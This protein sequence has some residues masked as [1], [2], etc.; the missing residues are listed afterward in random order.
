MPINVF[1]SDILKTIAKQQ[2]YDDVKKQ[3]Q[4]YFNQ[5]GQAM[6][7]PETITVTWQDT[8][9]TLS[10][11]DLIVYCT[12]EDYSVVSSAFSGKKFDPLATGHWGY[13]Y[14]KNSGGSLEAAS[15]I[16]IKFFI[17]DTI[18]KLALHEL[19]H[20]KLNKGNELH[21]GNGLAQATVA[22]STTFTPENIAAL[23]AAMRNSVPQ[24]TG[25]YADL[26]S[27][28][29]RRDQGDQMWYL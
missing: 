14:I 25:G 7:P 16:Y 26:A 21:K 9:P 6:K 1:L 3:L 4:G 13:T 8:Q 12:S 15:E 20:N 28:K 19:M 11:Q 29:K 5:I 22:S 17:A 23:A 10:S 27:R 2:L 18:A 24:W